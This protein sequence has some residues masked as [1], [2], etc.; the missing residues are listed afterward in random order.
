MAGTD[1]PVVSVVI[2]T[3]K[4]A[5]L[6]PRAVESVLAQTL[7]DWELIVSDDEGDGSPSWAYVEGLARHDGR[8]RVIA[9]RGPRGQAGNLNNAMAAARGKWIK[10]AYDD[11]LLHPTCLERMVAAV[12]LQPGVAMARCITERHEPHGVRRERLGRRAPLEYMS[13]ADALLAVYLTDVEIGTPTQALVRREAVE[14]GAWFPSHRGIVSGVD[15][16]WYV[17]LLRR[18]GLLLVNETLCAHYQTGQETITSSVTA[19]AFDEEM[20]VL[21]GL[22][23]AFVKDDRRAPS[24]ETARAAVALERAMWRLARGNVIEAGRMLIRIRDADAWGLA[25]RWAMRRVFPGRFEVVGRVVVEAR[26]GEG[27]GPV[28][29]EPTRPLRDSG[30]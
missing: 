25:L 10:P 2:P 24:L 1:G 17:E 13:G 23:H 18:G 5:Q 3:Y 8:V 27:M 28:G 4:R 6:L 11:D 21:R 7:E 19:R 14:S 29:V 26:K 9:N 30:F 22:Q 16:M 12:S 15:E 20:E